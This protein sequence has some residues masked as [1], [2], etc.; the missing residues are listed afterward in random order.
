MKKLIPIL[1]V[2]IFVLSGL[3]AV[4]GTDNEQKN[5]ITEELFFSQPEV[6]IKDEYVSLELTETNTYLMEQGKPMLPSYVHTF[7]FPFGT[8][9]DSVT[10]TP[11]DINEKTVSK[12]VMPTPVAS[13]AGMISTKS[14][15]S[16]VNY[17]TDPYPEV[18]FTYDVGCGMINQERSV[19][20]KVKFNPIKYYPA[21]G[22]IKFAG[23]ADIKV[24]YEEPV[25]SNNYNDEYKFVVIGPSDFSDELAPLITHKNGRG[26]STIFVTLNEVY[27]GVHFPATGRDEQEMIKYFIKNA[28][29]GWNTEYVALVGGIDFLPARETHIYYASGDDDEIFVSD[30]Y[31]AD[32]YNDTMGFCS[33]D[34]N[35]N[36]VFGEFNW[37]TSH[38]YDEVDLYPDVYLG[39]L[40]CTSENE[41]TISVNKIK[42][43]ETDKAYTKHWFNDIITIG[44]DHYAD[45][46]EVD[47]GEFVNQKIIDIMDGF[48]PNRLWASEGDLTGFIP[49]GQRKVSNAINM[50]CGFIDFSGHGNT[51]IWSTHPHMDNSVWIPTANW[52]YKHGYLNVNVLD[53]T[54]GDQLPIVIIGACS[55]CKYNKDLDCF[56]WSFI[57]NPDGGGIASCG[58]TGL[59]W[60]YFGEY[61]AEKGFEKIC[62]DSFQSYD[63]GAMT[64]GEMWD[65]AINYYIYPGMD[66]LDHKTVEE[67]QAFGDP[68]LAIRGDSQPPGKPAKPS[69]P[70]NGCVG[71]TYT[72]TTD[73]TD[74]E[75]DDLYYLF[76]W[77]DGTYSGW[78]G[79][80]SSGD[81]ASAD[82]KWKTQG[83]FSV[84]V[85]AKD[86]NGVIGEWSDPLSVAIPK[87][88]VIYRP[89]IHFLE[90]HPNMFPLLR[91]LL[92]NL[93]V[94]SNKPL[95][96]FLFNK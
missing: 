73:T 69:G 27:T 63:D 21:D 32:I 68:T 87:S 57:M 18:W 24:T 23:R 11:K 30:L 91:L 53:L 14:K 10:C 41:V 52:P 72:Y 44:G 49:S 94:L 60:F 43:Y 85:I 48:I 51:M 75:G 3:G 65:G 7:T 71:N 12:Y 96:L 2:G 66:G 4:S 36:D 5:V 25:G 95:F 88:K 86:E 19:I 9:I 93:E 67:F 70:I 46:S 35:G 79:P 77:G 15:Q 90:T 16:T 83:S 45:D 56:G 54:N 29:E 81:T 34:S 37:G 55:T 26:I 59:D 31:Y 84:K 33:W 47:E 8:I 92:Q 74:P 1:V 38:N 76:D 58:A 20:V 89:F 50:G 64:F 78:F 28:I 82:K 17:G 22:T 61:V 62:I 39:R 6:N 80:I 13:T 42:K 40:A